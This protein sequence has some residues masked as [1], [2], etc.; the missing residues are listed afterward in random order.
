[1]LPFS[2]N[3]TYTTDSPISPNDLNQIQDRIV[4]LEGIGGITTLI[5][6]VSP[7]VVTVAPLAIP[8]LTAVVSGS[9][10]GSNVL[11]VP[12]PLIVGTRIVAMRCRVQDSA[13]GPTKVELR[14]AKSERPGTGATTLNIS[15]PS[16]GDGTEQTIAITSIARDVL[17][18]TSYHA[19]INTQTGSAN[20]TVYRL[21][22]DVIRP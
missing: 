20:C 15:S 2:R 6:P 9:G 18:N 14:L 11:Y 12:L 7:P 4:A 1:M 21:E 10:S 17:Q 3:T 8:E 13:T 16:A 22:V 5:V 19:I